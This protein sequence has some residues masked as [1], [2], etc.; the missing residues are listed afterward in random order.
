MKITN[1][2]LKKI[3]QE[4]LGNVLNEFAPNPE[5]EAEPKPP[6]V[7]PSGN[8]AIKSLQG[9]ESD[10]Q[11]RSEMA[12]LLKSIITLGSSKIGTPKVQL[13]IAFKML[14]VLVSNPVIQQKVLNTV[15]KL[16][17]GVK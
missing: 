15:A 12:N 13:D 1:E 5:G 16:K 7:A 10:R 17:A 6:A 3:I 9:I 2:K 14:D 11:F 8:D 4:E